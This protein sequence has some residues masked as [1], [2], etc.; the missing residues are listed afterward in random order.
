MTNTKQRKNFAVFD[1]DAH[2]N[3]RSKY[4]ISTSSPNT[5]SW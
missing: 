3:D 4:G 2:I 1:C 5:V